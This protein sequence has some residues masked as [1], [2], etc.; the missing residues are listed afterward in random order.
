MSKKLNL[1]AIKD[2][3]KKYKEKKRVELSDGSHLFIY[4]HFSK[5]DMIKVFKIVFDEYNN[6][7][8]KKLLKDIPA[9]L[10]TSFSMVAKFSDLGI[11]QAG[12]K[13]RILAF[14]ELL[15]FDLYEEILGSF[16]KESVD[17]FNEVGENYY[18]S[19][20]ELLTG[21]M[22]NLQEVLA[23]KVEELEKEAENEEISE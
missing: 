18:S 3:N 1:T 10:W 14:N 4:P 23:D 11:P 19:L 2:N 9:G 16:P 15:K 17:K 22:D 7:E 21:S 6:P 12:L 8:N 20:N 13:N 5:P